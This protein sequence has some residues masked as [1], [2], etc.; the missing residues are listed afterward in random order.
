M[1]CLSVTV[2][3]GVKKLESS[4]LFI[5]NAKAI[6]FTCLD[7][8]KAEGI[9]SLAQNTEQVRFTCLVSKPTQFGSKLLKHW[10]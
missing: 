4:H 1:C 2:L 8:S 6:G 9:L 7:Q 5:Q 10:T 3:S